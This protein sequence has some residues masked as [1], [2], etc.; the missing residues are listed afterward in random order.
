MAQPEKL[1]NRGYISLFLINLIVSVSFSMVSTTVFLYVTE[2]GATAAVAGSVVGILSIASLCMRPFTGILS[3]RMERRRLL[4]LSQLVIALA[5][6]GCSFSRSVPLLMFFRI[7]HGIGFSVATTVTMAF[8]AMTIPRDRMTQGMGYFALGQTAATAVAPG[9]GLY[10]GE[11][12]G[13]ASTLRSASLILVC[14]AAM[15]FLCLDRTQMLSAGGGQARPVRL[16][17]MFSLSLLPL[18]ILSCITAGAT[19][20]ENSYIAVFGREV[21]IGNVGWY[22]SIAAV[23]LLLARVFGGRLTDRYEKPMMTGGYLV[24]VLAFLILGLFPQNADMGLMVALLA[25]A[26]ACKSLGLGIV[27]PALQAS[28]IRRAPEERR[29]IASSMYYLGTDVGQALAPVLGGVIMGIAGIRTIFL[30]Y[31]VPLLSAVLIYLMIVGK[32][33]KQ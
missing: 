6:L 26:A 13:Y 19:G 17:D 23:A 4:M 15:T 12:F 28:C 16:A 1:L 14:A 27:Q 29:G 22:F 2:I 20:I 9:I 25:T 31:L 18:C 33:N 11:H 30:V 5:M 7:L 10:L 32:E 8:V 24:M 3:D 21:G